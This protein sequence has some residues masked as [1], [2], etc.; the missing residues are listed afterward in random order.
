MNEVVIVKHEKKWISGY[1]VILS[2]TLLIT[3]WSSH[4]VT[5]FSEN[6]PIKRRNTI[7]IDPGHGG[8][9]GGATSCTGILESRFNL[10]ISLRLN[11]LFHFLGYQTKMIRTED[12]SV[13]RE[14]DTIAR[15]KISDLKER[16]R[17]VG[18]TENP[19]LLS[20]HQNYFPD[21]QYSGA[22]VFYAKTQNSQS[23]AEAVQ[24]RFV[25]CLNPG[26]R[27]QEKKS[28]GIY[29]MEHISCPAILIECGFLSNPE[30]EAKL[31]DKNYQQKLCCVIASA[32]SSSLSNT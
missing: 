14:G 6:A 4:A 3:C 20:I 11:D 19:V 7:V 2:L 10:E 30:E 27:R 8:I 13:Y 22:Q 26:S 17:M 25:K 21:G 24:Q 1:A 29:L 16:V 18:E 28:S 9:D 31:R 15:K 12:I 32:V 23:L 5:V